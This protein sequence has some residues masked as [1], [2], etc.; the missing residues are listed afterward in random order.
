MVKDDV[1]DIYTLSPTQ[2]GILFHALYDPA[3]AVY[4][5]QINCRL[6]GELDSACFRAAWQRVVD[7][8]P[9]LR[10]LFLWKARDK[11]L[12]VV[13]RKA[14]LPWEEHDWRGLEPAERQAR[15]EGLLREERSRGLDL[16]RA[17]LTRTTLIRLDEE[18]HR[19]IW[20][21]HHLLMDGWSMSLVMREVFSFY[22][23][24]RRGEELEKEPAPRYR[25]YISWL[26]QR[27]LAVDQ[28]FWRRYLA[29]L[30]APT[31]LGIDRPAS[32]S[33]EDD[34]YDEQS[35]GLSQATT[36]A[37]ETVARRNQLAVNTLL[38]AAWALLL[39]RYSGE[40][41]VLFGAT[42]AGRPAELPQVDAIVGVFINTLPV[43]VRVSPEETLIGWLKGLQARQSELRQYEAT[44]LVQIQGWTDI[45]RDLPLFESLLLFENYPMESELAKANRPLRVEDVRFYTKSNYPLTILY[46][47]GKELM[48][49]VSTERRRI[50][51][52]AVSRMLSHL[53]T[54]LTAMTVDLERRVSS[55]PMLLEPER[56]Q[57]LNE[58]G[59]G[60]PASL[61]EGRI[62]RLFEQ[63][64]ERSPDSPALLCG[65]E[66]LTYGELDRRADRL[67][68]HLRAL[69]VGPEVRV[70]IC[71]D[72]TP[73]MVVGILGILKAGGV[74]IPMDPAYPRERLALLL[75]DAGVSVLLSRKSLASGLPPGGARLLCLDDEGA[76]SPDP[77]ERPE[78]TGAA[79]AAYMI[80]TSGSTG[81]PKGVVVTH[82]NLLRYVAAMADRLGITEG[83]V[84][85]HTASFGFSSS[86]RQLLVPLCHGAAVVLAPREAIEDPPAL[87]ELIKAQG[88]TVIDLVPS[89]WRSCNEALAR[90]PLRARRA[91]LDN[92]LRLVVSAS[93]P[94]MSDVPRFWALGFRHGARL[95]NMF[96][97]TETTG[98]ATTQPIP[99]DGG[100]RVE[101]VGVGRPIAGARVHLVDAGL[102]SVPIGIPGEVC[103][104][105]IGVARG[106][107]GAPD[108][109]AARFIP[110]PFAAE[111]G[112]R[113]Y[114]T[115]D[116]GRFRWDG[117]LEFLGRMDQQVKIRGFRVELGEI[118]GA[119]TGHPGVRQ[120]V[121]TARE[122]GPGDRRLVAYVVAEP[123]ADLAADELR[124]LLAAR[125]PD[126]MVPSAYVFLE[127]LPLNPNG[128]IDR[129]ALPE[130]DAARGASAGEGDAAP[131]TPTEETVA[132]IW[133]QVLKLD[134]VGIHAHFSRLGGH[135]LLATQII[136]RVREAFQVELPL[137]SLFEAPTVAGMAE[138]IEARLREGGH[139]E[140]PPLV[141][142]PREERPPLSFAQQRLWVVDRM[143]PGNP[144][145]NI[146]VAVRLTGRLDPDALERSLNEVV[147]RHE[148]LR[149]T[150][151]EHQGQPYQVIV[152]S[153]VLELP[154]I[155]LRD[156]A[157]E[158]RERRAKQLATEDVGRPFDLAGGPLVRPTLL[159]LDEQEWVLI[160]TLHHIVSDAWS[161][162]IL[163]EELTTLYKAFCQGGASPLSELELQYAD[164]AA[165][166]RRWLQGPVLQAQLGYWKRLLQGA[167]TGLDLPTDHPRPAERSFKGTYRYL[168]LPEDLSQGLRDLSEQGEATLFMTLL[169]G[170]KTLLHRYTGQRDIVVGTP[171][172]NRNRAAVEKLI[173]FFA[174]T[175][176]LRTDLSGDPTFRQLLGRVREMAME[177][178][179]RQDLPFDRLVRELQPD[180]DLSRNPLFQVMFAVENAPAPAFDLPGLT[181]SRLDFDIPLTH[182]D[183][184]FHL[185]EVDRR[186]RGMLN[187]STD[188]FEAATIDRILRH[189][190]TL[191][192]G[193]VESPD[194]PIS[195]L[196]LIAAEEQARLRSAAAAPPASAPRAL[197]AHLRS[198]LKQALQASKERA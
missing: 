34:R 168:D 191:L 182:F 115:G 196:P 78:P 163:V 169:A 151:A 43:R 179:S 46:W 26:R 136:S 65:Q 6:R 162:G 154:V 67:A 118:E 82:G 44:P 133:A 140:A 51:P 62:Q 96:G 23:A 120:A 158:E 137:R 145:Y 107:H 50:E 122:A 92:A 110:D 116:L 138:R 142:V 68:S 30:R 198:R 128:K 177:A 156:K 188:L 132:K 38:Q 195:R 147:R 64:A 190:A 61:G 29:G 40:Q 91:L 45:P 56:H 53:E 161:M 39:S 167:Q 49:K 60:P 114:R 148:V 89:Y 189:Y 105:G 149:T 90:L 135:S 186:I 172:A 25:S 71:L 31:P 13:L 73:E 48:L 95:V 150:F 113:L 70:G 97:Q 57:C 144:F 184:S 5:E 106:Y 101:V 143:E 88:V 55:L 93:E 160:L 87:F 54:L 193:I 159:H 153:L 7:R 15:L 24:L 1:E 22:E 2:E 117:T 58:W 103:I 12:Q 99:V 130:P 127:S 32:A 52:V 66:R 176:V 84:Y 124:G 152:P 165:W 194:L 74:W 75:Q 131:R 175:L 72:R 104:G 192:R 112:S 170:F 100:E 77:G 47:P 17:P 14:E 21:F 86:V 11:P 119:L 36:A 9:V 59:G 121:V 79:G 155:D 178:W 134:T 4:L 171:I 197:P 63:W 8:H 85:L 174:N 10:T 20:T 181:L 83:D 76:W 164:F 37:L 98:I 41:D 18:S 69:G 180:R 35:I 109:T 146:P 123:N 16:S 27:D 94:L 28:A 108:L 141:P 3:A 183:I 139:D 125:L 126:Y 185:W 81:R 129:A 173:G 102:R 166:Q 187:Y 111:P 157:P 80:Y 33:P 42:V 19:F